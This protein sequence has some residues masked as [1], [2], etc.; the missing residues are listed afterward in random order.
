MNPR[1]WKLYLLGALMVAMVYFLVE[2]TSLSK[3][4]LYNG[5]GLSAVIATLIGIRRNCPENR[6]AWYFI[7]GGMA[8]FLTADIIY[9]VLEL[10]TDAVPYPSVADG[11]YLGCLLYTSDAADD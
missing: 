9:Y 2:T 10:T 8:S 7:A 4:V 1:T 3:L 6:R 11:F 5:I